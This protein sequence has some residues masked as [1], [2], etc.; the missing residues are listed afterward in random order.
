MGDC[1]HTEC[2]RPAD[3]LDGYCIPHSRERER[4][5]RWHTPPLL[6]TPYDDAWERAPDGVYYCKHCRR[7]VGTGHTSECPI[8]PYDFVAA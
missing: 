6:G 5:G 7:E 3:G 4:D 1:R 2:R 8:G